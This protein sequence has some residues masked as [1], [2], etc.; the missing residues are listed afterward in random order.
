M[1]L[2]IRHTKAMKGAKELH[3]TEARSSCRGSVV[4]ESDYEP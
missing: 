2:P 1:E 4:N 3:K